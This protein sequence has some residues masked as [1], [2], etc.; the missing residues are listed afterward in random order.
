MIFS[1]AFSTRTLLLARLGVLALCFAGISPSQAAPLQPFWVA[2]SN[3]QAEPANTHTA[4]RGSFELKQAEEVEIRFLGA[5]FFNLWLDGEMIADG[6]AR[7]PKEHPEYDTVRVRV[8]AGRHVIAAQVNYAGVDTR[9]M[10]KIPPFFAGDV[11]AGSQPVK[12]EWR[13]LRLPGVRS[14]TR[15]RSPLQGWMEWMNTSVMPAQWQQLG[16][17][18]SKWAGVTL[19]NPGIGE[20]KPLSIASVPNR[21]APFTTIARGPV[22]RY[23][24][25]ASDDPPVAFFLADLECKRVPAQ[26]VWRRYDLGKVR[27]ARPRFVLD[28]PAGTVVEF[29]S[30]EEL[31]QGRVAPWSGLSGTP[32]CFVDYYI[33]RGGVQ[34]FCPLQAQGARFFEVHV[35]AP[36]DRSKFMKEE[37]LERAYYDEPEGDFRCDDPL[38]EKVWR[39]GLETVLSSSE[40]ALV[41]SRR[42]RGQ[43]TGDLFVGMR[44]LATSYPDLRLARRGIVQSAQCASPKGL[45]AALAPG[46]PD[47]IPGY[48]ALWVGAVLDYW[49]LTGDRTLLT[50]MY[51]YAVRNVDAMLA[52]LGP[53]GVADG[54]GWNFIDWGYVP[55]PGVKQPS[56]NPDDPEHP[57][58]L[59]TYGPNEVASEVVFNLQFLEALRALVRWS[60][61]I[62][63]DAS[64]YAGAERQLKAAMQQYFATELA[65]GGNA[66][67]RIG[68]HRAVFGLRTGLLEGDHAQQAIA[69]IKRYILKSFPS[70]PTAPRLSDPY[71]TGEFF[72]PYFANFS[73]GELAERGEMNF[74]LDQYRT[75]WGWLLKQGLT[76]W[77]EVFDPRWSHCH[78]WSG[79]PTWMLSRHVLGLRPRFDRGENHFDCRVRAGALKRAAGKVALRNGQTVEVKWTR[80]R[81]DVLNY[82]I[83]APCPI[84]LKFADDAPPIE[85]H[86]RKVFKLEA[87]TGRIRH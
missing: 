11:S 33:A 67:D 32:T 24:A 15:R 49:E 59:P 45:V 44:I 16:F 12:V 3:P 58:A 46:L 18:D 2:G 82:E 63:K 41:D 25:P 84:W 29:G 48:S 40:D 73:L 51:P 78:Q 35:Y 31:I 17:D 47:Y 87:A 8:A 60:Q 66:W 26:G 36:K 74:V 10:N 55:N 79:S 9:I 27:I 39:T 53:T 83:S 23:F 70:N 7:F 80:G 65:R 21:S 76:T 64:H 14:D 69:E 72:T 28:V 30:S 57:F 5:T 37:F 19:C 86:G 4:F 6:P 43:W 62:G 81:G 52:R 42:E 22:A 34:E 77:P 1:R 85:L 71:L 50:E 61:E 20:M 68:Y 13:S 56:F 75:S 54:F 38:L